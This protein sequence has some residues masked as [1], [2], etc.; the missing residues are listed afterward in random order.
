MKLI[1]IWLAFA[2]LAVPSE[3]YDH[4]VVAVV[5]EASGRIVSALRAK[6]ADLE[7]EVEAVGEIPVAPSGKRR[8]VVSRL[9]PAVRK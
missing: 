7:I 5:E 4:V 9:S 1:T 3:A 2:A 6:G 8:F